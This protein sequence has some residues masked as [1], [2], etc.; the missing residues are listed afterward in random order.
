MKVTQFETRENIVRNAM[1]QLYSIPKEVFHQCICTTAVCLYGVVYV[2]SLQAL[3]L[4]GIVYMCSVQLR[5][6]FCAILF[7]SIQFNHAVYLCGLFTCVHYNRGGVSLWDSLFTSV[8]LN[9]GSVSVWYC[10]KLFNTTAAVC[11][12]GIVYKCVFKRS[13]VSFCGACFITHY[14]FSS[15]V[16][17]KKRIPIENLMLFL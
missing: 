9:R 5:Q 12:R 13:I 17:N 11:Q 2:F 4:C 1:V 10:L 7:T 15:S 16:C 6:C 3:I 8:Q 14:I